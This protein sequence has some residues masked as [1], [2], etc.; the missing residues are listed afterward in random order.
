M[1]EIRQLAKQ[2]REKRKLKILQS[3]EKDV[4]G[5]RMPRAVKKV[6]LSYWQRF[7]NHILAQLW[8]E[9]KSSSQNVFWVQYLI[10]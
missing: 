6:S 2:I 7:I 9:K 3:K 5:P 4:K 8:L 1:Q 10:V